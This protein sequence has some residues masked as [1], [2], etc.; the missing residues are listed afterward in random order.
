M[1]ERV[2]G[3]TRAVPAVRAATGSEAGSTLSGVEV[4]WRNLDAAPNLARKTLQSYDYL[5]ARYIEGDLGSARL[6]ELTPLS[7]EHWKAN[8][9]AAGVGVE[10]VK[11]S[12]ALVQGGV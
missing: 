11:G 6:D 12:P 1:T 3:H 7:L 4:Q 2:A 9:L 5:W 8:L 10:R